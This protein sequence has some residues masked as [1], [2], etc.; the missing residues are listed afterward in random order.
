M[1]LT[2]MAW[3]VGDGRFIVPLIIGRHNVRGILASVDTEAVC[4]PAGGRGR[5]R[6]LRVG[7]WV[8]AG[9]AGAPGSLYLTTE[10]MPRCAL[11][12]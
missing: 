8:R 10:C 11:R 6:G 12:P 1:V 5:A 4:Q 7:A 9:G 3:S 2:V